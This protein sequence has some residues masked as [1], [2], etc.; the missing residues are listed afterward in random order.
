L[1]VV[2]PAWALPV[3]VTTR[4]IIFLGLFAYFSLSAFLMKFYLRSVSIGKP[5]LVSP[6]HPMRHT[7][8]NL[9]LFAVCC[10]SVG[11]HIYP[12]TLPIINGYDEAAHLHGAL[13]IYVYVEG[14]WREFLGFPLQYGAWAGAALI[15]ALVLAATKWERL[16]IRER[17]E[18][19]LDLYRS[20]KFI[21]LLIPACAL[22]LLLAYFF[23]LRNLPYS[24]FLVRFPPVAKLLYIGSY[25]FVGITQVGP[26]LVQVL[27]C[28]LGAVYL[29]RTICL[30][31]N[32][33]T[34][35]LGAS[36]YLF[37]P[38]VFCYS[39]LAELACGT[40]CFVIISSFY[41]LRF[42][43]NRDD[44][45]LL[46][47]SFFISI[48]FLY[49]RQVLVML[50]ICSAYLILYKLVKRDLQL[51]TCLKMMSVCLIPIVPWLLIGKIYSYRV[52]KIIWSHFVTSD[53]LSYASM[54]PSQASWLIFF[55]FLASVIFALA[56]KRDNLSLFSAFLFLSYY[57]FYTGDRLLQVDRFSMTFVPAMAI[58]LSQ[59]LVFIVGRM[60]WK[61][62]YQLVFCGLAAYLLLICTVWRAPPVDARY[63]TYRNVDSRYFPGDEAM[64]WV[65]DH[66]R[67]GEKILIIRVT[68]S[69]FYRE[70][71]GIDRRKV[72]HFGQDLQAISTP[73]KLQSY[74]KR[75]NISYVMHL[76]GPAL[77]P[78]REIPVLQH[79]RDFRDDEFRLQAR[80][81]R[82]DNHIVILS[83]E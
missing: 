79:L 80:F 29:Y 5:F 14:L 12:I 36:I 57:L 56:K 69:G 42:L 38:L 83:F 31:R 21:R 63:V 51:T 20:N 4:F 61:Y 82:G 67:N 72:V 44:R 64:R 78:T 68:S 22:A 23:V 27:F 11:L 16:A 49:K 7:K 19:T 8:Q 32:R 18:Q 41:F 77:T 66:V 47:V 33:E 35:L 71:Y 3:S 6:T 13:G 81:N 52:Y 25:L 2:F 70:Q 39:S 24:E 26:R 58:F 45:D 55:L 74:R 40:I 73:E 59:C 10:I 48:G 17:F 54:I 65:R 30:F 43:R 9:G 15:A 1:F 37:S 50:L 60:K 75:N 62:S 34:A 28:V 76:Y 46:L 53:L